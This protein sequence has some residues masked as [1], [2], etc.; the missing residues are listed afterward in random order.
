MEVSGGAS[1]RH[2][3]VRDVEYLTGTQVV[4]EAAS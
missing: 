4:R 3:V 1:G 2:K